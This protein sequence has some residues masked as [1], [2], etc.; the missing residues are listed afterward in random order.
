MSEDGD[1]HK[2]KLSSSDLQKNPGFCPESK[3]WFQNIVI[4]GQ[5]GI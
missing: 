5:S 4:L 3:E 2:T 1:D